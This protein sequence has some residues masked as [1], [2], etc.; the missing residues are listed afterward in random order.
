[1][2]NLAWVWWESHLVGLFP[3]CYFPPQ[4]VVMEAAGLPVGMGVGAGGEGAEGLFGS[5]IGSPSGFHL[6]RHVYLT[7][8]YMCTGPCILNL[9]KSPHLH[10]GSHWLKRERTN[11]IQNPWQSGKY[12]D[13]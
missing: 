13:S 1:M 8:F 9:P 3:A 2:S 7:C 12:E 11:M 6:S 10:N 4:L 5:W